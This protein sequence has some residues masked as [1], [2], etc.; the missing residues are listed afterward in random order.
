MKAEIYRQYIGPG[1]TRSAL[2]QLPIG[3]LE[4]PANEQAIIILT[5]L[6]SNPR[7]KLL[8]QLEI[9]NPDN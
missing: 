8:R 9:A 1:C 7:F 2:A 5:G 6:L 3:H 4:A